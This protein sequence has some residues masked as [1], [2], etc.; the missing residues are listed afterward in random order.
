MR[1]EPAEPSDSVGPSAPRTIVGAI[2][3]GS[4]RPGGW[5]KNPYGERSCSPIMLLR[6][7]PV[8]GTTSPL[9]SPLVHVAAQA[10]PSSS[11]AEMWVVE[12]SRWRNSGVR[13]AWASSIAASSTGTPG[14]EAAR[15]STRRAWAS[16]V[17]PALGGGFVTTVVPR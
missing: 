8:P 14:G 16:R 12:P 6:W 17:P 3:D 1:L 5:V 4:R 9:P 11:I 7:M 13:C 15:S 2:I 10:Q